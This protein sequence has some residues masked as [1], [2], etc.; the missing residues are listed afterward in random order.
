MHPLFLLTVNM[1]LHREEML[2]AFLERVPTGLLVVELILPVCKPLAKECSSF[3]DT[4]GAPH[5]P[6]FVTAVIVLCTI[7]LYSG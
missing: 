5:F 3:P 1:I 7:C 2:A 4:L 6:F